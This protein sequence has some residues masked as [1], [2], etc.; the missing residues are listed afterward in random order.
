[1]SDCRFGVLP[2]NYPDPGQ[3]QHL[4]CINRGCHGN[5]YDNDVILDQNSDSFNNSNHDISL[6]YIKSSSYSSKYVVSIKSM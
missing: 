6:G 4:P 1:M 2:V 3:I 5:K